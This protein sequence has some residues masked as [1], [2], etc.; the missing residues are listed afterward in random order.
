MNENRQNI[1]WF[2]GHMAKTRRLIEENIKMI[3]IVVEI[4]DARI[5][6]S[7]QNPLLQDLVKG[8]DRLLVLNKADLADDGVSQAWIEFFERQE[9][10]KAISIDSLKDGRNIR[11]IIE[12]NIEILTREKRERRL[13]RGIRSYTSRLMIAGIPNVGKSTFINAL[14]GRQSAKTGAKPGVTRG[15]QWVKLGREIEIMDT[16]GILWPKFEDPQ[17]AEKLALTGAIKDEIFHFEPASLSLLSYLKANYP[18]LLQERYK[19][20]DDDLAHDALGLAEIIGSKRGCLLRGGQIDMEKAASIIINDFRR[21]SIGRIS[22]E[23]PDQA[24]KDE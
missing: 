13:K 16:P 7:S 24:I 17:A 8:K 3:D 19:L 20:S 12:R 22:L 11:R 21:G 18:Q 15:K 23:R 10:T 1:N 9:D 6:L 4:V 14:I 5:P 2:P